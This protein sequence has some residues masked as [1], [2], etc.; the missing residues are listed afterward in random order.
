MKKI[1]AFLLYLW[2]L[3]QNLVGLLLVLVLQPEGCFQVDTYRLY[4][5]SRMRGAISLGQYIILNEHYRDYNGNTELHEIGHHLQSLRL[6]PLYLLVIGLPS[7]V[8]AL[9]WHGGG[10]MAYHD[11]YTE[12]WA[13]KLGGVVRC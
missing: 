6:G 8:W 12:K 13:D 11:F 4:Y 7:L 5:A 3:P 10:K 2:Q 1:V 9:C